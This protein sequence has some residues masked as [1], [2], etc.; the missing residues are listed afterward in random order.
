MNELTKIRSIITKCTRLLEGAYFIGDITHT[1]EL[2][3]ELKLYSNYILSN[4]C[5]IKKRDK[6]M[7]LSLTSTLFSIYDYNNGHF[8]DQLKYILK[9]SEHDLDK[10]VKNSFYNFCKD[11]KYFFYSG[12]K[13]KGYKTSILTHSIIS[14]QSIPNFIGFLQELYFHDLEE[15]YSE[16]EARELLNYMKNIFQHYQEDEDI[17]FTVQGSKMTIARQ[18]LPKSFRLAFV[19]FHNVVAPIVSRLLSYWHN[20][21]FNLKI[22]YKKNDRF[23]LG[24][25]QFIKGKAV[26][27]KKET[28][29]YTNTAR[30]TKRVKPEYYYNNSLYLIIPRIVIP[31]EYINERIIIKLYTFED[32]LY[33]DELQLAKT[34]LFFK[35]IQKEIKLEKFY[36]NIKY[37]IYAG[38]KLLYS[39][40][41][42]LIRDFIIFSD[43]GYEL[44]ANS[45]HKIEIII[46][47]DQNGIVDS[48]STIGQQLVSNYK[49]TYLILDN[50]T[51][52]RIN[53]TVLSNI[54]YRSIKNTI[55]G[56]DTLIGIDVL[57]FNQVHYKVYK[58][59]P[60]ITLRIK[61]NESDK[62][63]IITL[64]GINH[65]LSDISY[66]SV[67]IIPDGSEDKVL[68]I[69]LY[70]EIF[71][72]TSSISLIVRKRGVHNKIIEEN[73][74]LC[75]NLDVTFDKEFYYDEPEAKLINISSGD[76]SFPN[77]IT[78]PLNINLER[79]KSQDL[80]F[81]IEESEYILKIDIPK[82][83]WFLSDITSSNLNSSEIWYEEIK[84]R[85]LT[86]SSPVNIKNLRIK[87]KG[88][89]DQIVKA[90][91]KNELFLFDLQEYFT[92]TQKTFLSVS[93]VTEK[94]EID[95]FNIHFQPIVLSLDAI[96]S[97]KNHMAAGLFINC[98]Y[99]GS[100]PFYIS[101]TK[102]ESG[103]LIK[104]YQ[105]TN[106]CSLWDKE[107]ILDYGE[108]GV[109]V[110][111]KEDDFFDDEPDKIIIQT[112]ALTHGDSLINECKEYIIQG[113][114][115]YTDRKKYPVHNF[116]LKHLRPTKIKDMYLADG[117]FN[118]RNRVTHELREFTFNDLNPLQLT[119]INKDQMLFE[120]VDKDDDG[121]CF[122]I[123]TGNVNPRNYSDKKQIKLID[124]IEFKK[125][126]RYK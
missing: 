68:N 97:D 47:T 100:Y 108:Y 66:S 19:N 93:I 29:K 4:N 65:D 75:R 30:I 37:E 61:A 115:C 76:I 85:L 89:A 11:N 105:K 104:D 80:N 44:C 64:N 120:I 74:V 12:K 81:F 32:P 16:F 1:I 22:E 59:T 86:V 8:W 71:A 101:I 79:Y 83:E 50:S 7:I 42:E 117:Y 40:K 90:T 49:I 126:G 82:I 45:I 94:E 57:D 99:V 98:E 113:I 31:P 5:Y 35:T 102:K 41:D 72:E 48:E 15:D 84:D 77:E 70:E 111:T 125:I 34:K 95:I 114:A 69:I 78:F 106:N 52:F 38:R 6:E 27:Q 33:E 3:D 58:S 21:N 88:L 39:S 73:I 60:S 116:Y 123:G 10:I 13:N 121:I 18:N 119:L 96:Y 43:D 20:Y 124:K 103:V 51:I 9:Y 55:S 62:D 67:N 118:I 112:K 36:K 122:D 92:T 56:C 26:N 109:E 14:N 28:K 17:T 110:Y 2:Y 46:L 107:L 53:G 24:F 63:Y 54:N 87:S 25:E 91:R 23:D